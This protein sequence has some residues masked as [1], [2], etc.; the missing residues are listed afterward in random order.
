MAFTQ[1]YKKNIMDLLNK[2]MKTNKDAK[3]ITL[4]KLNI[5]DKNNLHILNLKHSNYQKDNINKRA[6][7]PIIN[8]N[9]S[10]IISSNNVFSIFNNKKIK[11]KLNKQNNNMKI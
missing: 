9:I 8:N 4:K 2:N 1:R 6:F 11:T 7:T 3:N 5:K 10:N